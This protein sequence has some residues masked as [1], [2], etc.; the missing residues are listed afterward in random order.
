MHAVLEWVKSNV[1]IVV[2]AALMIAAL[3]TLPLIASGMNAEIAKEVDTRA[4]KLNELARLEQTQV[5]AP[6]GV[7]AGESKAAI[8]NEQ[9]LQ[10]FRANVRVAQEDADLVLARAIEH[11]RKGRGVLMGNVFP[12][13]P[14]RD[15][16]VT[17]RRFYEQV[18]G[19]VRADGTRIEGAYE[20]LLR[21]VRAGSP[22]S[23]EELR[24]DIERRELQFRT[25]TLA[26]DVNDPLTDEEQKELQTALTNL[27]LLRYAES[28]SDIAFY[29]SL[30]SMEVP[31]FDRTKV[32]SLA[33]LFEWQWKYWIHEDV[34]KA[35]YQAN[36][37][38]PSVVEAPVKRLIWMG[39][40][41]SVAAARGAST[42]DPGQGM[43]MGSGGYD[44]G[45]QAVSAG[46]PPDPK[47]EAP[48]DFSISLTG[49]VSNSLYDVRYVNLELIVDTSKI[50][51][52]LDALA[53]WNFMTVI[54]LKTTPADPYL[55]AANGYYYGSAPVSLVLMTLETVWFR[56]W[57]TPFMPAAVR[58]YLGAAE[59]Q[60]SYE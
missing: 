13:P 4:R 22:P 41:G 53:R 17:P 18:R 59:P 58:E 9:L 1:F 14:P 25:H 42:P 7:A 12:A 55:A 49:R 33:E 15:A 26:K 2:F 48:V 44:D 3:I 16:E 57:T 45:A 6:G 47:A 27:R 24:R 39:V 8:V 51:E 28:T 32:H 52:V 11:N 19:A 43:M 21:E 60:V 37:S 54:H 20:R 29:A 40:G 31:G 56:Q 34:L 23:V 38:Y 5:S 30:N 46:G 36:R 50:P 10:A 35:L